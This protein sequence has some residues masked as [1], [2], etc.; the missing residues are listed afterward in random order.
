MADVALIVVRPTCIDLAAS[1]RTGD[2]VQRLRRPAMVILN[3]APPARGG[4]ERPSVEDALSALRYTNLDI[5]PTI[6]RTR[7][8]YHCALAG[9]CS[10]EELD[11][12]GAAGREIAALWADLEPPE[13]RLLRA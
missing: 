4:I 5:A 2:M 9:G 12:T 11:P 13:A 3:Q 1:V 8:A 7:E 6:L 10:A